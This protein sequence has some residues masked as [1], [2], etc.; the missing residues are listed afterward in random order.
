MVEVLRGVKRGATRVE[1]PP[2]T[3]DEVAAFVAMRL[4]KLGSGEMRAIN[5]NDRN[6]DLLCNLGLDQLF[7]ISAADSMSKVTRLRLSGLS[8]DAH[9]I[10][11]RFGAFASTT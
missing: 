8:G 10:T 5:L 2:F 11:S 3:A 7:T 9:V 1:L 6:R 4:R